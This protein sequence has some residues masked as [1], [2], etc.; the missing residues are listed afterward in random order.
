MDEVYKVMKTKAYKKG[1]FEDK[2]YLEY[3][4]EENRNVEEEKELNKNFRKQ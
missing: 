1:S 3:V 2:I 4:D